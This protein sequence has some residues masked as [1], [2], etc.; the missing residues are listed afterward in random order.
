M[1]GTLYIGSLNREWNVLDWVEGKLK[2]LVKTFNYNNI[3]KSG[4]ISNHSATLCP[5]NDDSVDYIF[6]D[7]PFG[8]NLSYSELNYI[9]ESW[10]K[11]Y[12]NSKKE[13]IENRSHSKDF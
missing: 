12:T 10:L 5:I 13:A 2:G 8:A 6:T 11:V 1:S 7:P 3:E 4:V 9:W